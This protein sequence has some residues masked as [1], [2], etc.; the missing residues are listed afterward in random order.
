MVEIFDGHLISL[1]EKLNGHPNVRGL[2][3]IGINLLMT[4]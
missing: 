1:I 4:P 2:Q 3:Y